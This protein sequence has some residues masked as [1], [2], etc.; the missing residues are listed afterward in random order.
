[1]R[2]VGLSV[3]QDGDPIPRHVFHCR[4]NRQELILINSKS[5]SGKAHLARQIA[6]NATQVIHNDLII[7]RLFLDSNL[8][9]L[10][11]ARKLRSLFTWPVD[12]DLVQHHLSDRGM[13]EE[14]VDLMMLTLDDAASTVIIEGTLA[15]YPAAMARITSLAAESFKV[16]RLE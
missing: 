15:R 14:V 7:M 11:L 5:G 4:R 10:D 2:Y 6:S 8:A 9:S 13:I 16:W 12:V 1:M 3:K